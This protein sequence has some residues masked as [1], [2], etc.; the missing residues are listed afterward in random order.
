MIHEVMEKVHDADVNECVAQTIWPEVL[1][2]WTSGFER[3]GFTGHLAL[4][5]TL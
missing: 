3:Y 5:E 2:H 4:C 1:S